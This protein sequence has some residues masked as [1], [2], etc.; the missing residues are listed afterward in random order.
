MNSEKSTNSIHTEKYNTLPNYL[1]N[2]FYRFDN[3][4]SALLLRKM[5][6]KKTSM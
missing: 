1:L 5:N 4:F 6:G 2:F 3:N